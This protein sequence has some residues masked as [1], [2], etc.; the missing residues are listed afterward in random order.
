[1][2]AEGWT[3]DQA[4]AVAYL[5]GAPRAEILSAPW[6]DDL[7]PTDRCDWGGC[8]EPAVWLVEYNV[9]D[10]DYRNVERRPMCTRHADESCAGWHRLDHETRTARHRLTL[11]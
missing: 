6:C 2:R 3:V 1:M 11:Y 10:P 7:T 9:L 8:R 5:F 4:G